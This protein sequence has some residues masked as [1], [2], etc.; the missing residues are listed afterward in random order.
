MSTHDELFMLKEAWRKKA[1]AAEE[2][3]EKLEAEV[4]R[5]RLFYRALDD[6]AVVT[7]TLDNSLTPKEQLDKIIQWNI[8]VATDPRTNGG[9]HELELR[10]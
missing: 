3:V 10:G 2:K 4:E 7:G 9:N 1:H 8:K 5:H 6:A